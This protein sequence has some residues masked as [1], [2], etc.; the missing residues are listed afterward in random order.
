MRAW[1]SGYGSLFV[2]QTNP[3]TSS[4]LY[5]NAILSTGTHRFALRWDTA[6]DVEAFSDG[7]SVG[8]STGKYF[9]TE[10]DTL[11]LGY[12]DSNIRRLD[13]HLKRVIL[14]PAALTDA[15]IQAISEE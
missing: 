10:I 1:Q 14:Y 8:T 11:D 4:L 7:T 6:G 9:P 5:D 15:Q 2:V 12:G 13:G 3:N